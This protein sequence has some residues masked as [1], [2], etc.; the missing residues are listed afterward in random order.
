MPTSPEQLRRTA[1]NASSTRASSLPRASPTLSRATSSASFSSRDR[2]L[3]QLRDRPSPTKSVHVPPTDPFE[4]AA[5]PKAGSNPFEGRLFDAE[6]PGL[7]R[8]STEYLDEVNFNSPQLGSGRGARSGPFSFQDHDDDDEDL[9]GNTQTS[10]NSKYATVRA[11]EDHGLEEDDAFLDE[12][13][14]TQASKFAGAMNLPRKISRKIHVLQDKYPRL[15]KAGLIVLLSLIPVFIVVFV[16]L[17]IIAMAGFRTPT[18]YSTNALETSALQA[19]SWGFNFTR[20]LNMTM[21]NKSS[22]KVAVESIDVDVDLAQVT[23]SFKVF[24]YSI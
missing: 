20:A 7:A 24:A 21:I 1:S 5:S 12:K 13:Q 17:V 15:T 22:M 2:P 18:I 3:S 14:K 16:V 6:A 9:V 4:D 23:G 11:A 10:T 8:E 19:G